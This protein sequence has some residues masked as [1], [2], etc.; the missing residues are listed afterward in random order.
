MVLSSFK[1]KVKHVG[2]F[3]SIQN[4]ANGIILFVK[5][6]IQDQCKW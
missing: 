2:L 5:E 1:E 6:E 4:F 3:N